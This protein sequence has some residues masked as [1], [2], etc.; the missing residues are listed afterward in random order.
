MRFEE[1]SVGSVEV[2]ARRYDIVAL[3]AGSAFRLTFHPVPNRP[4]TGVPQA[5]MALDGTVSEFRWL[6]V[7]DSEQGP[8]LADLQARVD[9]L[10][11]KVRLDWLSAALDVQIERA[12]DMMRQLADSQSEWLARL[13]LFTLLA[14][15]ARWPEASLRRELQR[16]S[17]DWE[18]S[19]SDLLAAARAQLRD[20]PTAE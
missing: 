6:I 2:L 12:L 17:V 19:W 8:S 3:W 1:Q 13:H 4:I 5:T 20:R 18:G 14:A 10:E 9:E 11:E 15:A 7:D 16:M